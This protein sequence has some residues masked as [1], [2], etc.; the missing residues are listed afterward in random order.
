MIANS[1]V[2]NSLQ[3]WFLIVGALETASSLHAGHN[4]LSLP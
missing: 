3:Q 2:H 4:H 1:N